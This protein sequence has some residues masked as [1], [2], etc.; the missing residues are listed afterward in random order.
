M[1]HASSF[2][3][4]SQQSDEDL[5]RVF[6]ELG[7]TASS[8]VM[9]PV[10]RQ[11]AKAALVSD[12]TV[13][14]EGE[15]GTGKLVLARAI[16]R[17]DAKRR[18]LPFITVHCGTINEAL[19][20]SE[21]FGHTKGAFSG[22]VSD[23]KGLFP[24]AHLG[25][26]FLDDVNDLPLYLQAKLLDVIQRGVVRPVGSDQERVIDVR[27][28]AACNQPLKP[29]VQ[30]NRFRGDLYHRLNVVR[31]VLPP[32]RSRLRDLPELILAL[33]QR[34]RDLYEPIERVDPELIRYL[35][36]QPF[37][38][39]IRELENAVQR[40]LFSKAG[41]SS[42]GIADW[43]AQSP[44]KAEPQPERETD[45]GLL[46]QAAGMLWTVISNGMSYKAAIREVERKVLENAVSSGGETR[47]ELANRIRTSE[48][49]LY[50]K[51][52]GQR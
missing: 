2:Q 42:L 43:M 52:R 20:E 30:Q 38:G 33:A 11:A 25:T 4:P 48:R 3:P 21:L 50:Y 24:S 13:L 1:A 44:E 49:T 27:I 36:G 28:I 19:A 16:H 35:E 23:R 51:M 40:M 39:N 34:H 37:W 32:L 31:L 15:T 41:G 45:P 8:E 26:L 10:L 29:L 46:D 47:R 18:N 9:S 17:L 6:A 14:V 12:V 22:A 7:L 5:R